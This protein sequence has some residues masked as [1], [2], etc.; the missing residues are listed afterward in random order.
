MSG[1]TYEIVQVDVDVSFITHDKGMMTPRK[2]TV[3]ITNHSPR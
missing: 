2:V 1:K 3:V